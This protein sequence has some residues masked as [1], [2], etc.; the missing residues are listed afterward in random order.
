MRP[1]SIVAKF[2][3]I[4]GSGINLSVA[5]KLLLRHVHTHFILPVKTPF[6]IFFRGDLLCFCSFPQDPNRVMFSGF[7]IIPFYLS[8]SA[9]FVLVR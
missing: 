3:S 4:H 7:T 2:Y 8:L 1:K 5:D 6:F 9:M